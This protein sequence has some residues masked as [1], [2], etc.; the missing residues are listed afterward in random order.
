MATEIN[1]TSAPN[2]EITLYS[3]YGSPSAIV[4]VSNKTLAL[5]P[6]LLITG[7]IV[8]NSSNVVTSANVVWTDGTVGVYTSLTFD[9]A[10][11]AVNSYQITKGSQIYTQ[12]TLTR[13][14]TGAVTNRPAIVVT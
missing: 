12:P 5:D 11:G 3:E 1:I 2:V 6:E 13:N 14:S 7:S 9:S 10:T 4:L 8:R